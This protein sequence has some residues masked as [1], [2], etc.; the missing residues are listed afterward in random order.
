MV[1]ATKAGAPRSSAKGVFAGY[2]HDLLFDFRF[3]TEFATKAWPPFAV[4]F[5]A[6]VEA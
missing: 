1:Y 5:V 3:S 4:T 2:L 6:A